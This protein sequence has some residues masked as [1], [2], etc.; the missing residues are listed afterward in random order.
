MGSDFRKKK[1][2]KKYILAFESL[3]KKMNKVQISITAFPAAV[4]QASM[5]EIQQ[6]FVSRMQ[7]Q[8]GSLRQFSGQALAAVQQMND[9]GYGCWCYFYEKHGRGRGPPVDEL[10][11]FCKVLHEGYECAMLDAEIAGEDDC[12]PWTV[13]YTAAVRGTEEQIRDGCVTANPNNTCAQ[14][15]CSVEGYFVENLVALALSG[16]AAGYDS[17]G[18]SRAGF[19]PVEQ[20]PTKK[21]GANGNEKECCGT[22]TYKTS[23]LSCCNDG[24][25]KANC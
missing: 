6:S 17:F 2:E 12:E 8:G 3:R 7:S 15:A 20:C 11:G 14:N 5:N 4:A 25:V 9:E 22:R 19:D 10:D 16:N 21:G 24:T 18:H 13:Q 23:V 1:L